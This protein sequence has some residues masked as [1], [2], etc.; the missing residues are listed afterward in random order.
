MRVLVLGGTRFVGR[1]FVEE[2]LAQGHQV[3]TFNRGQ[4]GQDVP[5]A[6]VVRGDRENGSDLL[7]LVQGREWDWVVDT[8]G[9]VP[10]VVGNAARLLSD[11]AGAYVFLSTISVYPGWPAEPVDEDSAVY[12]CPPDAAGTAEDEA[13]WSAAQYGAY[14]AGCERA[15]QEAFEGRVTVLRP[16]VILGPQENVGRLTWWLRRIAQGGRVL[17]PGQPAK[18]IQPVD[19]RDLTAFTLSCL[20]RGTTGAFNVTAPRGHATFG[21]ML[22]A[23]RTV[24]GSQAEF[25]WVD[26]A[27][28]VEHDVRQWTEIPLWRTPLGTW[29]VG[30]AAAAAAGLTCRP[31]AATVRDT[32]LWLTE[33][34]GPLSYGRQAH[35]GLSRQREHELLEAWDRC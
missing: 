19:I 24:T 23:C 25:A 15:V 9:Y 7:A 29:E 16:G 20:Q 11:R 14:K 8:S 21:E 32:H 22:E 4:T 12:D 5:G 27:F 2:A 6:E 34:N 33:T 35:H 26:D 1:V 10:Q 3:T 30:A 31:I 17:A 28:L 13:N 18:Q